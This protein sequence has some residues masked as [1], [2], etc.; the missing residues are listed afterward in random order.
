MIHHLSVAAHDPESVAAFFAVMMDGVSVPFPPNP[1]S[2]M[3]FA[4]DGLGTAVEVYPSGS[5]IRQAG[6]SGAEFVRKTAADVE[7]P[8]HFAL[9]VAFSPDEVR[10]MAAER[11]WACYECSRGGDFRVMEIWVENAWLVEILPAEFAREY[12]AFANRFAAGED[13]AA[14]MRTHP[15]NLA[16]SRLL[17][18]A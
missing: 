16:D 1:G 9:S 17:Q 10:S 6:E 13:A 18:A 2:Y 15:A 14:L 4:R 11:D 3:A 12:L 8:T 7:S 5:V